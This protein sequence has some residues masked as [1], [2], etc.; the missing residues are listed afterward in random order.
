MVIKA[1]AVQIRALSYIRI[2]Y[3]ITICELCWLKTGWTIDWD[4]FSES[5][6]SVSHCICRW[7][8]WWDSKDS[9]EV[10]LSLE[11]VRLRSILGLAWY[12]YD[13][14]AFGRLRLASIARD[15]NVK[16]EIFLWGVA[17]LKSDN[18]V[19]NKDIHSVR[20]TWLVVA[21]DPWVL[22]TSKSRKSGHSKFIEL[23]CPF[24]CICDWLVNDRYI[25]LIALLLEKLLLEERSI[26]INVSEHWLILL[27]LSD[28]YWP[29]IKRFS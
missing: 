10:N 19:T 22:V 1:G 24:P 18:L 14:F 3:E 17:G 4:S 26:V 12:G 29:K 7:G 25:E 5:H 8:C 16:P 23:E 11:T 2:P 13:D 27:K 9:I 15:P 20:L 28:K 6:W 21:E